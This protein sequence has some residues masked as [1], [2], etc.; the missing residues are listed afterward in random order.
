[1]INET[2]IKGFYQRGQS[3]DEYYQ[4]GTDDKLVDMKS[5]FTLE[6]QLK[7]D[8]P[9]YV[10][11]EQIIIGGAPYTYITQKYQDSNNNIIYTIITI[12]RTSS[13]AISITKNLYS[14]DTTSS[15]ALIKTNSTIINL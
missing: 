4:L 2:K 7:L 14:G 5:G 6:E 1:M 10:N 12:L 13:S 8:L 3:S 11:V 9:S 15:S